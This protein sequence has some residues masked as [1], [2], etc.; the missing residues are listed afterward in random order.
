MT[1]ITLL[2]ALVFSA[3]C[4]RQANEKKAAEAAAAEAAAKAAPIAIKTA[5]ADTKM[6]PRAI[7]ITGSLVPDETINVTSEVQGRVAEIR[8][9]FGQ[10]VKKGDVVVQIDKTD[11]QIQVD[12]TRAALAQALARVGLDPSQEDATPKDT[13]AV[14]SAR[15]QY[16]DAQHKYQNA[17]KLVETGDIP[18]ERFVEIEKLVNSRRG[19]LDGAL[20]QMRTDLA[21]VMVI[22][23]EKRLAEKRLADTTIRAPFDGMVSAKAVSAGQFVKDNT[24]LLTI[25]KS[26]PLRLRLDVPEVATAHVFTGLVLTFTTEALPGKEFQATVT[27]VNPSLD[28]RA[29]AL[30]AEARIVSGP[31]GLRPGMFVQVK[32]VIAK[33]AP[34]VTVPNEAL[35]NVA[36]LYKVF[37]VAG[38]KVRE[39]RIDPGQT[40]EGWVEIPGGLI[41]AGSQVAVSNLA[42]LTDNAL[43]TVQ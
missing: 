32:L 38:G 20:D 34:I 30:T 10:S 16:E 12:R 40:G 1:R 37:T 31:P 42:N 11:Y 41:A 9:D 28:A 26:W 25:V 17:K 27:N 43:V 35:Y 5:P 4:S 8:Y 23:A 29:R 36:G 13:P 33:G 2:A 14:R 22:R 3:A 21:N 24:V 15:A 7:D 6:V 39:H 18:T 19:S